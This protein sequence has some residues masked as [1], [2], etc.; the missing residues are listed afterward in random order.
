MVLSGK[1]PR[2]GEFVVVD[3]DKGDDDDDDK[4]VEAEVVEAEVEAEVV[5]VSWRSVSLMTT[6]LR[7]IKK[8]SRGRMLVWPSRQAS[9]SRHLASSMFSQPILVMV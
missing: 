2:S 1:A 7:G 6:C 3:C 5:T 8:R 9:S 4:V